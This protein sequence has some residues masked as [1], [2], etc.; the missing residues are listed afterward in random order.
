MPQNKLIQTCEELLSLYSGGATFCSF[1]TETTGLNSKK[2]HVVEIGAVKFNN[3]GVTGTFNVLINPGCAMPPEA[4]RVNNITDEM[5]KECPLVEQVLPDFIEFIGESIL[6]AHNV[7][8][9]LKFINAELERSGMH[10]LKNKVVDTLRLSK[11]MFPDMPNHKLQTLAYKLGI[12][13]LQ[14][15]RAQDDARV[16]MEL[17]LQ[18]LTDIH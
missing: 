14:A 7:G 9:D 3:K 18:C 5:L 12:Q 16:C 2:N 8:F 10:H 17:F 1:D 11:S 13:A 6:V 4:T 15:H